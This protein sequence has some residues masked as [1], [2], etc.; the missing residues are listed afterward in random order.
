MLEEQ[1]LDLVSVKVKKVC[2]SCMEEEGKM[3]LLH[4]CVEMLEMWSFSSVVLTWSISAQAF[5]PVQLVEL[6]HVLG[7]SEDL[8][9]PL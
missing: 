1:Q 6:G 9:L 4:L 5:L 8:G 7:L 2:P 3:A